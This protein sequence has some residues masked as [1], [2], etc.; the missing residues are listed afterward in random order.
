MNAELLNELVTSL[1]AVQA[2][3]RSLETFPSQTVTLLS[4]VRT[5]LKRLIAEEPKPTVDEREC[6]SNLEKNL[7]LFTSASHGRNLVAA[8]AAFIRQVLS[9]F[10]TA[11]NAIAAGNPRYAAWLGKLAGYQQLQKMVGL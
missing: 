9:P 8:R 7:I 10:F 2:T 3:F 6:L 5:V 1:T 4:T 11:L